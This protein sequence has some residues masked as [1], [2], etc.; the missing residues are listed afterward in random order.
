MNIYTSVFAIMSELN[1]TEVPKTP[2]CVFSPCQKEMRLNVLTMTET[3]KLH[4]EE[5]VQPEP[6][7][8]DPR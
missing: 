7:N 8:L 5:K 2:V 6:S 3:I 4:E 1:K